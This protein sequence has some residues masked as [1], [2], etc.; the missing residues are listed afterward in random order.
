MGELGPA[1]FFSRLI[2]QWMR[3]CA[4]L[5]VL[6]LPDSAIRNRPEEEEE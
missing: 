5:K 1:E 2:R 3:L 6:V 4:E